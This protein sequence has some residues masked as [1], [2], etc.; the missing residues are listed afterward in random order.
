MKKIL[1]SAL[2]VTATVC[3]S[4]ALADVNLYGVVDSGVEYVSN[5]NAA[6]KSLVKV[7]SLTGS[8]PSRFGFKGGESLGGGLEAVFVLESGFSPDT[9][10][11]GQGGR[12]FGRQSYVGLKGAF[13][14]IMF[15]RQLNMT[16]ISFLKADIMG[17]NIHGMSNMDPYLPNARSDNAVG[18][19]GKFAD[20]TVGAT[21]STGRDGSAAGGPSATNCGGEIATDKQACRQVTAL[22]AYDTAK[23]GMATAYDKLNGGPGAAG[24]LTSS[25]FNVKRISLNGYAMLGSAKLGVG[26]IKRKTHTATDVA[27]DLYYAGV[28]YPFGGNWVLDTQVARMDVSNCGC[29]DVSNQLV[30]RVSYNFSRRTTMYFSAG[31]I[32]NDGAAAIS[33]GAGD[34]VGVGMS[35][36]GAMLGLRHSF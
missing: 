30:A 4:A 33:I 23:F 29:S 19:L 17:P 10:V 7:P 3:S 11:L 6:G 14:T 35:Q 34:A 25:A 18:Y 21:Y 20:V 16:Y 31:R 28:S 5:T 24:G 13:G 22:L 8:V 2:A 9:G 26:M 12:V 36:T 1:R 27:A 32:N 15:G